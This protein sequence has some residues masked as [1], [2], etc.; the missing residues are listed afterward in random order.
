[1]SENENNNYDWFSFF[2]SPLIAIKTRAIFRILMWNFVI[3]HEW[4][5]RCIENVHKRLIL[6]F[7]RTTLFHPNVRGYLIETFLSLHLCEQI[8]LQMY[9]YLFMGCCT[10]HCKG[11]VA[12]NGKT[13]SEVEVLPSISL[14]A[15][16]VWEK[17]L[18][19]DK[20]GEIVF[21]LQVL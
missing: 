8:L 7:K 21:I 18:K 17:E 6:D 10:R 3:W 9:L 5:A 16:Q 2:S 12:Q 14:N 1:M 19:Y 15:T 4:R 11:S 13:R 20:I